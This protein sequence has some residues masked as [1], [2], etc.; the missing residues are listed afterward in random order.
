M[1]IC[2]GYLGLI[3]SVFGVHIYSQGSILDFL[4]KV[5]EDW[6]SPQISY[7]LKAKIFAIFSTI[8]FTQNSTHFQDTNIPVYRSILSVAHSMFAD[9]ADESNSL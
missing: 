9:R 5:M 6:C 4:Q 2:K 1:L 3:S 7:L 8:W